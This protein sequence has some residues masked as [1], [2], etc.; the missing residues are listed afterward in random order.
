M[1]LERW[2]GT[3]NSSAWQRGLEKIH[4]R[5]YNIK[6]PGLFQPS[7]VISRDCKR[8]TTPENYLEKDVEGRKRF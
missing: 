2:P 8:A 1:L 7:I 4:E 6:Y 3:I 5:I